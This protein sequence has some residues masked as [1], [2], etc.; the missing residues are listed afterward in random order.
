MERRVCIYIYIQEAL[1][2]ES[3][4]NLTA[5]QLLSVTLS[6]RMETNHLQYVQEDINEWKWETTQSL[7]RHYLQKVSQLLPP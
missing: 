3:S 6:N 1:S 2:Y 4:V 5:K 7:Q